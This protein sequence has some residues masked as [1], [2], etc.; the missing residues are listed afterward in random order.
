MPI[1][2]ETVTAAG[3]SLVFVNTYDASV[4]DGY[5]AA[6]LTAETYLQ[7]HFSNPVVIHAEF[8]VAA[9]DSTLAVAD[10]H[11]FAV[12]LTYNAFTSALRANATTADDSLAVNGLPLVDPSGG[13]GFAVPTA[14]ARALGFNVAP[15]DFDVQVQR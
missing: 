14:E 12:H 5:R 13:A 1:T 10:N 7:S 11:F 6:I 9:L 2:S 3:S 4:T 8:G 15:V